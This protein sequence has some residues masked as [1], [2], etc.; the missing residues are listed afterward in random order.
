MLSGALSRICQH[1]RLVLDTTVER[2]QDGAMPQSE[3][4]T[5]GEAA[6]LVGVSRWTIHN[7]IKAGVYPYV[8]R[9]E[10]GQYLIPRKSVKA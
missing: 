1:P 8:A 2:L 5:V 7:R 10:S 3:Y 9:T 6:S 4:L